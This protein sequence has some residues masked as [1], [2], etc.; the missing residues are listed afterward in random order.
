LFF[1]FYSQI[2]NLF[3]HLKSSLWHIVE[4][5]AVIHFAV[6]FVRMG[7]VLEVALGVPLGVS[8]IMPVAIFGF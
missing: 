1:G 3:F 7:I 2:F 4:A 8:E 6:A 5:V